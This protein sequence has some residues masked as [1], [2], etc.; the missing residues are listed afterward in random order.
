MG[1]SACEEVSPQ[2]VHEVRSGWPQTCSPCPSDHATGC[3][4][5]KNETVFENR[6]KH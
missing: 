6:E 1:V 3:H 2:S 5:G 4:L